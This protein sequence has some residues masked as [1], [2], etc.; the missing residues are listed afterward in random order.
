[1]NNNNNSERECYL[2]GGG[3]CATSR[4]PSRG[5]EWGNSCAGL[6]SA[7]NATE[8]AISVLRADRG[9]AGRE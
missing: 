2:A 4:Y 7:R 6:E 3:V 9:E 8:F 5:E 1:M